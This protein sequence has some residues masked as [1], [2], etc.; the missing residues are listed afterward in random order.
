MPTD[1]RSDDW[2]PIS[3]I[4]DRKAIPCGREEFDQVGQATLGE[5][6]QEAWCLVVASDLTLLKRCSASS[7]S[8]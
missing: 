1:R 5:D 4:L 2:N 7:S 3:L 6:I 8:R